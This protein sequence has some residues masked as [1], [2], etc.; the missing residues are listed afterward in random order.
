M[1]RY[2]AETTVEVPA[3]RYAI[4][5]IGLDVKL[6]LSTSKIVDKGAWMNTGASHVDVKAGETTTLEIHPEVRREM[7]GY[8]P[9][10]MV[11]P[12]VRQGSDGSLADICAQTGSS[13][14]WPDYTGPFKP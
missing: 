10:F 4:S 3:G 2:G 12:R 13:I 6:G 9:L 5:C 11:A 14:D 8:V 1:T 7:M